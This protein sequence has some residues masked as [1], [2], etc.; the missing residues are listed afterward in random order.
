MYKKKSLGQHFLTSPAY[1]RTIA[2]VVEITPDELVVEIGPGEGVLTRELLARGAR[3]V[4]V[5]K[6][7]RLIPILSE[8]FAKETKTGQLQIV[9]GDALEFGLPQKLRNKDY[10]VVGNIPYYITGALLRSF[11]SAQHQPKSLIFLIQKEVA[12]RIARSKKE[13]LLSLSVKVYGEP[14]YIKTVPRGAFSP[15][16]NVDSAILRVESISRANFKNS[17]EEQRFFDLIHA[18]FAQKRKLLRRNLE[19]VLGEKSAETLQ[20]ANIPENARAEDVPL[21]KWLQLFSI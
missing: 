5:E 18:G 1:V 4:A 8:T 3:V 6:D 9:E 12:E 20:K 10:K 15:A 14:Q 19:D 13:S 11:L 17:D 16:P 2:D 7:S 21:Q